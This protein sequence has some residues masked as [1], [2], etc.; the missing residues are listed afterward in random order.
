MVG[1]LGFRTFNILTNEWIT[2]KKARGFRMK[3][4]LTA[5]MYNTYCLQIILY[6]S[7]GCYVCVKPSPH[8]S[9][10]GNLCELNAFSYIQQTTSKHSG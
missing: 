5:K 2:V 10:H 6:L 9:L 3:F 8:T 1:W 4:P 7:C